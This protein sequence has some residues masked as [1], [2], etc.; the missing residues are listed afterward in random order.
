M[1][2]RNDYLDAPAARGGLTQ[3]VFDN[4]CHNNSTDHKNKADHTASE[5][6]SLTRSP[7]SFVKWY[8]LYVR[9]RRPRVFVI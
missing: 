8:V 2:L 5:G 4:K 3:P 6:A 9:V 1:L 7:F